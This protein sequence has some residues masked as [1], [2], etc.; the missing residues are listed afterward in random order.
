MKVFLP[1][2]LS[3]LLQSCNYSLVDFAHDIDN[4]SFQSLG[5]TVFS[6]PEEVSIK[7]IHLD[8][9]PMVGRQVVIEGEIVDVGKYLTYVVVSDESAR[10]LVILT[11]L[12]GFTVKENRN[13]RVKILGMVERG[14]KGIPY[15]R[16][17][18]IKNV[19]M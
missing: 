5:A 1:L 19:V 11:G 4:K 2:F 7:Q 8:N 18:A 14:K 3:F 6:E 15:V 16:A 12:Q 10:M 13:L 17:H 9:T